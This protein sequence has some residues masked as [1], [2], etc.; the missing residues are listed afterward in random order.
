VCFLFTTMKKLFIGFLLC[1]P[2]F[3]QAQNSAIQNALKNFDYEQAIKLISK[4]KRTPELDLLKAKC[5]KN[6]AQYDDA[7]NILEALVKADLEHISAVNELAE[8]YLLSGNFGKAKLYYFMMLQSVPNNR[9]ARLNY[10]NTLFKLKDWKQTVS[11]CKSILQKDSIAVLYP[12]LGDCYSQLSKIDSAVY[13]YKKGINANPEDY[14]S[15]SKLSKLYLQ[16]EDY[17]AL[18][19]STD[20]Y[21]QRDSSNQQINQ[22]NGIGNC[23]ANNHEKAIYRLGKLAQQGD[24]S[25]LTN[26]YLG[27][28]Y[29]AAEDYPLAYKSLKTAYKADSTN[30]KIC[31]Y[32]GKSAI[33]CEEYQKGIKILN[34]GLNMII[35]SDST[36]FNYYFYLVDGYRETENNTEELKYLQLAY[37]SNPNFRVALYKIA[38]VYDWRLKNKTE[39]LNYYRQFMLTLPKKKS[40][41]TDTSEYTATY[42]N[43]AEMRIK[44]LLTEMKMANKKTNPN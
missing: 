26:F 20:K 8:C 11:E 31:L 36:L 10:L 28:C 21:I 33:K 9:F 17:S 32:L 6:I 37:K 5:Y 22:Y 30:T 19:K 12:M 4:E 39:A 14:N 42:Y 3:L 15:L 34:R 35:P 16:K 44:E 29:L 27:A 23:L 7:I 13:Y 2:V 41:D 25:F 24:S 1:L 18:I 43:V 40:G 38:S